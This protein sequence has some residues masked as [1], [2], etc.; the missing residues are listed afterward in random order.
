MQIFELPLEPQYLFL[1]EGPRLD[2]HTLNEVWC[3]IYTEVCNFI[4]IT[5]PGED[6]T[7]PG[8]SD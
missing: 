8:A 1:C 2:R 4:D 5:G 6:I 7:G 3:M